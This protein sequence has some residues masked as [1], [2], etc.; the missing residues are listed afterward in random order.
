M[1][2]AKN[3][4]VLWLAIS[5]SARSNGVLNAGYYGFKALHQ[6]YYAIY[7]KKRV[8]VSPSSALWVQWYRVI[9]VHSC[10]S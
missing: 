6:S 7:V 4:P 2:G 10:M 8:C 5:G 1:S 3:F 9:Y